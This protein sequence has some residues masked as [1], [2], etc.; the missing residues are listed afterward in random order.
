[1][2]ILA[3]APK[4]RDSSH[5]FC[6]LFSRR[7]YHWDRIA[8]WLAC[9]L[10]VR[11]VQ[12]RISIHPVTRCRPSAHPAVKWP[13]GFCWGGKAAGK[14]IGHPSHP[15]V[16]LTH[17]SLMVLRRNMGLII[18][19]IYSLHVFIKSFVSIEILQPR[20]RRSSL[21]VALGFQVVV[22]KRYSVCVLW[23]IGFTWHMSDWRSLHITDVSK[24]R[25]KSV[26]KKVFKRIGFTLHSETLCGCKAF[27]TVCLGI[28]HANL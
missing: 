11:K 25:A 17:L 24:E 8:Q 5:W 1:M 20:R 16:A 22:S 13:P 10:S 6:L 18:I 27:M 23:K 19:L 7:L 28:S 4:N 14:R 26:V 21:V 12:V 3:I 2:H 9:W 15:R